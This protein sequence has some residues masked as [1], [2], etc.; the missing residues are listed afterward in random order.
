MTREAFL[1]L[2]LYSTVA[3][4]YS[5]SVLYFT[6]ALCS[7]YSASTKRPHRFLLLTSAPTPAKKRVCYSKMESLLAGSG[8]FAGCFNLPSSS[9]SDVDSNDQQS[10]YLADQIKAKRRASS[11]VSFCLNDKISKALSQYSDDEEL[12]TQSRTAHSRALSIVRPEEEDLESNFTCSPASSSNLR[13]HLNCNAENLRSSNSASFLQIS[14]SCSSTASV[15][16]SIP[17]CDKQARAR[18]FDYLIGAIDEAWASYCNAALYV[19]D[20]TYGY[21]TPASIATDD[22]DYCGNTTDLTD[23]ESEYEENNVLKLTPQQRQHLRLQ[24]QHQQ[25]QNQRQHQSATLSRKSYFL[26]MGS[27]TDMTSTGRDPSSCRLQA[28]KERLIKAKYFLQDLVDS[29]EYNDA[30]D[31]WKRWDMI[32]YA[33]IELVEDDDD[34]VVMESTIDELEHGRHFFI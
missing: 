26:G 34:D 13:L 21:N 6:M 11:R 10:C 19:E 3:H 2:L 32:K 4:T 30:F 9:D 5:V 25:P 22:E 17:V 31:F 27:C 8:R 15:K 20:E 1:L 23:Y 14:D 7:L 16:R 28:L 33:T 18:C 29:D 24:R 12:D